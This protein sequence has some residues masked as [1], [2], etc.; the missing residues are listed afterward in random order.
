MRAIFLSDAHLRRETEANYRF[1]VWFFKELK[2]NIEKHREA[3]ANREAVPASWEPPVDALYIVGDFF[4]F[5]FGRGQNYYPGFRKIIRFLQDFQQLGVQVHFFEGNHDFFLKDFFSR[6]LGIEVYESETTI[7]LDGR[8]F[9]IAHGDMVDRTN[10]GYLMLR[11]TLRSRPV[12]VLQSLLPP[13]LLWRIA[14]LSSDVSK[15][16]WEGAVRE[17]ELVDKMCG[18]ALDI[19]AY[20][21]DGVILGHSHKPLIWTFSVKDEPKVLITLGDWITHRSYLDYSDG[22]FTLKYYKNDRLIE[23]GENPPFRFDENSG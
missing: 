13:R 6:H 2:E 22:Q 23:K 11:R 10:R 15:S 1:L 21:Y 9:Y 7:N 14:R 16:M 12:R 5:W 3:G 8:R 19:S 20:G 18:F 4:D 17:M